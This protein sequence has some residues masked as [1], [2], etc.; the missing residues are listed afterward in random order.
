[1]SSISDITIIGGGA[2]GLLTAREFFNAGLS[3]TVLEKGLLGQESSWAGGGI[4]LPL[5]PWRQAEAIS[6]LVCLSH[7]LYPNLAEQLLADTGIDPQWTQSGLLITQNPDY[8]EAIAWCER[9][10]VPYENAGAEFFSHL[11][12][13]TH[14]PLWLPTIAQARNP[15]LLKALVQDARNKGIKL[16]EQCELTAINYN[17]ARVDSIDTTQ[18][19]LAINQVV[20]STGAWTGDLFSKLFANDSKPVQA[21]ITPVKGQMLLFKARPDTLKTM[22]LEGDSYLIPRRDGHILAGSTVEHDGFN[23]RISDTAKQ[24]LQQFAFNLLPALQHYPLVNH[25]AGLRPATVSGIPYIDKHPQLDNL[26]I[27]AGHFRNGLIMGP[28]SAQLLVDSVLKRGN[29]IAMDA[30][31]LLSPH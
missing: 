23:K 25:W 11:T 9:Y 30:Y 5:Y 20:I 7:T 12:T 14:K 27:N 3:V 10:Q 29:N 15:R 31:S 13:Q 8:A 2:V 24:T 17:G 6:A 19:T 26:F 16:I 21:A 4:L 22:V 28:A 1:M 18:G